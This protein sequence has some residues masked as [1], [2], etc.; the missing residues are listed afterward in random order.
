[1]LAPAIEAA[2]VASKEKGAEV[3]EKYMA[4]T[5]CDEHHDV[6]V[7]VSKSFR[8]LGIRVD[9]VQIDDVLRQMEAW[10]QKWDAGHYIAVTGMHGVTEAQHDPEFAE[11]LN[12]ASLV[13]PDGYPLVVLGRWRGFPLKRRV[14]G[15][16]LL[17][18]FC[19]TTTG[20]AYRH[21][22]YGGA[23]GVASDL[24]QKF[25]QRYPDFRVAGTYCPPFRPLS[26]EEDRE[27]IRLIEE[28]RPDVLWIGLS[29]PK[30]ERWMSEHRN[31]LS[32]PVMVGV[33]AAFDFHT[34]RAVQAPKWMREHGF[35][36]L[37]RLATEP[38]RLW[39]RYL[40]FGSEFIWLVVLELLGLRKYPQPIPRSRLG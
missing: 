3:T 34:G 38:R 20:K 37:F 29:T 28:S 23:P 4:T 35:E 19:A 5:V 1:M 18:T 30:Q 2:R 25:A 17:E 27:V 33:G 9:A 10:I 32:V 16:E 7:S 12:S 8:V 36:W 6:P 14:Y 26:A 13:V 24:A 21:F 40:I 11:I 39:R 15:P 22:F 31:K